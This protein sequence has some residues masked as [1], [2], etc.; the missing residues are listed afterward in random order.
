MKRSQ[1]GENL[2][3]VVVFGLFVD[4]DVTKFISSDIIWNLATSSL[5]KITNDDFRKTLVPLWNSLIDKILKFFFFLDHHH[6]CMD[7][8]STILNNF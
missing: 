4:N 8:R 7:M 3:Q 1:W 6:L 2:S 5:H